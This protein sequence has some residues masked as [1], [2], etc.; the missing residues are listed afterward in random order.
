MVEEFINSPEQQRVWKR[1]EEVCASRLEQVEESVR[2][3][4]RVSA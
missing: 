1:G 2:C 3:D 4:K